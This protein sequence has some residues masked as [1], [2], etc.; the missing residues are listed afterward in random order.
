MKRPINQFNCDRISL[1][2]NL[3][4]AWMT[5]TVS[6]SHAV[7]TEVGDSGTLLKRH[8]VSERVA[9]PQLEQQPGDRV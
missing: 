6:H 9:A 2:A 3:S 8:C 7:T 5:L 1:R 4:Q